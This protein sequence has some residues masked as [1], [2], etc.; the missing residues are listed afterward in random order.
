MTGERFKTTKGAPHV[1]LQLTSDAEKKKR[2][3]DDVTSLAMRGIRCLAV[4]KTDEDDEWQL[5]GLLTFLDPP[6][7]DT[8]VHSAQSHKPQILI[9][10]HNRLSNPIEVRANFLFSSLP[11]IFI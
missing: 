8:K 10:E 3:E 2:C 4:A 1:I 6:R 11:I 9:I 5:L 7:H